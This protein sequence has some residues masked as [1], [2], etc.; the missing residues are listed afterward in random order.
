MQVE[1]HWPNH[2]IECVESATA[3]FD[4]IKPKNPW[5]GNLDTFKTVL[6]EKGHFVAVYGFS[7][8]WVFVKEVAQ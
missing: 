7:E 8:T 5:I 6:A 4:L 2:R 1:I 3:A